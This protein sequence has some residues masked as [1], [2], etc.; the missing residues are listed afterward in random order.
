MSTAKTDTEQVQAAS[1]VI[2][3]EE[4]WH[5]PGGDFSG[6]GLHKYCGVGPQKDD[7]SNAKIHSGTDERGFGE[8]SLMRHGGLGSGARIPTLSGLIPIHCLRAGDIVLT[9]DNGPQPVRWIGEFEVH[10]DGDKRSIAREVVR[11]K[12][13][14]FGCG[15]PGQD[16]HVCPETRIAIDVCPNSVARGVR[17]CMA[18]D[19]VELAKVQI[20][21]SVQQRPIYTLLFDKHETVLAEGL[22]V[23][24]L[25]LADDVWNGLMPQHRLEIEQVCPDLA[26][27]LTESLPSDAM[28]LRLP[29]APKNR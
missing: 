1:N 29:C 22:E 25:F 18:K 7:K 6:H 15:L 24:T 23:E 27:E 12:A 16:I 4:A 20:T 13:N 28:K 11:I 17:F 10:A 9:K 26:A 19:F 21:R 2:V 3:F 8:V 5:A 14:A